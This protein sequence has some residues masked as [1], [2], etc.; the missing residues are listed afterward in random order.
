MI[1]HTLGAFNSHMIFLAP[2]RTSPSMDGGF[3]GFCNSPP[4]DVRSV[5]PPRVHFL[6]LLVR[7]L[8]A[9]VCVGKCVRSRPRV[10]VWGMGTHAKAT[11]ADMG[12]DTCKGNLELRCPFHAYA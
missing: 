5:L 2:C 11:G 6:S 8:N 12:Q 4:T 3:S 1:A 7:I 9:L 10:S